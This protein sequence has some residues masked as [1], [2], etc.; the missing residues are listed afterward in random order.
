MM[1]QQQFSGLKCITDGQNTSGDISTSQMNPDFISANANVWVQQRCV[2]RY[3]NCCAH[4]VNR[5]VVV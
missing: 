3:A 4:E 5:Y 2:E 1:P